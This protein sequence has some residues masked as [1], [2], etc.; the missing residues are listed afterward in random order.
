MTG[1][2]GQICNSLTA[3]LSQV[4]SSLQCWKLVSVVTG[5][6]TTSTSPSV[7]GQKTQ[8]ESGCTQMCRSPAQ[9]Q[10]LVQATH[11]QVSQSAGGQHRQEY[12]NAG[13]SESTQETV[14]QHR[15]Q[16]TQETVSTQAAVSQHRQ[17]SV[18]QA[19]VCQH[20]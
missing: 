13:N 8:A 14:S 19:T 2:T 9:L 10:G 3:K 1:C 15:K 5:S 6:L 12:V 17:R 18:K 4:S 20:R 7:I 11:T 16:S